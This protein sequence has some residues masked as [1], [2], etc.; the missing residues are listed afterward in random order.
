MAKLMIAFLLVV[1]IG[2]P[3]LY[4]WRLWRTNQPSLFGWLLT[5]VDAA[6]LVAFVAL[7]GRWDTAGYYTMPAVLAIFAAALAWSLWKHRSKP[8]R[9]EAEPKRWS[10]LVSLI[11]FS[12]AV[13]Y[14]ASGMT[15]RDQPRELAFPLKGGRFVAV[16]AGGVWL[17]NHHASHDAQRYA[18]DITAIN[19]FGF[20]AIGLSPSELERYA[21]FG[22]QVVSPCAGRIVSARDGL[23]DLTPPRMDP[24]N[25]AG[26]HAVIDCDGVNVLVAHLKEGSVA[27]QAGDSIEAGGKIGS[28][29]NS[30]N[31]TEP[32]LHIHAV[33][34]QTGL[35]VPISFDGRWPVRNRLYRN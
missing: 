26:N 30:G 15:P 4:A 28:V 13:A 33:N 24:E 17:L 29:G 10:L 32:H 6:V 31:T 23:P 19:A 12:A 2:F 14:L 25:I 9:A 7:I 18:A 34:P 1:S 27:V 22:V 35:G 16:Q 20:R 8:W 3:L 21:I 11:A 5:A